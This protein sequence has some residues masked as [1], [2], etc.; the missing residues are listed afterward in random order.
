MPQEKGKL[1]RVGSLVL[2]VTTAI[3]T[4]WIVLNPPKHGIPEASAQLSR[5]DE[6]EHNL[7]ELLTYV[8]LQ[9]FEIQRSDAVIKK[10][11]GEHESLTPIV[12]ADREIMEAV[13]KVQEE[14]GR[15]DFWWGVF[16]GL[17]LNL[18]SVVLVFFGKKTWGFLSRLLSGKT[19]APPK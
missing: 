11:Q 1:F 2:F 14:K 15:K 5:L 4:V 16:V 3:A 19:T 7:R 9:K 18:L 8:Q 17:G 12:N 10:L 13:F 6:M